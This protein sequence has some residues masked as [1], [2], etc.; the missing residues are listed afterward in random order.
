MTNFNPK[1]NQ[2]PIEVWEDLAE[3]RASN[4]GMTTKIIGGVLAGGLGIA[5]G[6][7][8]LGGLVATALIKSA[9]DSGKSMGK[10]LRLVRDC[11]CNAFVLNEDEFRDYVKQFG[12]KQVREEL[13]YVQQAGAEL[14]PFAENWL[15]TSNQLPE[16]NKTQIE[17]Q[18]VDSHITNHTTLESNNTFDISQIIASEIP[19]LFIIG[20]KG[21]GKGIL[22][23]NLIR[24]FKKQ[25]PDRKVFLID[26]K[27]D[28]KEYGY[29][30]GVVDENE[31]MRLDCDIASPSAVY[32]F[33]NESLKKYDEFVLKNNGGL[34][35][36]DEFTIIGAKL[37]A[38]KGKGIDKDILNLK[39]LGISSSGDSRGKNIWFAGQ[40]PYA[41]GNGTDLTSL[42]NLVKIAL[43]NKSN[44][45][46]INDWSRASMFD[47]VDISW[48]EEKAN[49]SP[50]GRAIYYQG[51]TKWYPM[52][53]LKNHSNYDRDSRTFIQESK[54]KLQIDSNSDTLLQLIKSLM[55]SDENNLLDALKNEYQKMSNQELKNLAVIVKDKAVLSGNS[56]FLKKFGIV[57]E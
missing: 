28:P 9:F 17:P 55:Q 13:E 34:L 14:S 2:Y 39:I 4:T 1:G 36:V 29:F 53:R 48:V 33:I 40:S 25:Y 41:G 19:N 47:K 22:L 7:E 10:R 32:E 12:D 49:N 45:G 44:I 21:T 30:D 24:L 51:T 8:I 37:K 23:A 52:P 42:S 27:N 11:G 6:V 38:C 35:I 56:E 43:V 5:F 46:V 54:T 57:R 3:N 18:I 50:V 26:G 31:K 20:L 16:S 15:K